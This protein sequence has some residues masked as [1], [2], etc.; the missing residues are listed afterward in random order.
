[1]TDEERQKRVLAWLVAQPDTAW[2]DA[3]EVALGANVNASLVF[4][5]LSA[6]EQTGDV[7]AYYGGSGPCMFYATPK[8]RREGAQR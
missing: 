6:L 3:P 2:F 4:E 5:A 8:A 7:A 1:M